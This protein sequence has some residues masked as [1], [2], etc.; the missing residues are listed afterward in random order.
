MVAVVVVGRPGYSLTVRSQ[1][2]PQIHGGVREIR[3]I[4]PLHPQTNL[5]LDGVWG[6]SIVRFLSDT[7]NL[8]LLAVWSGRV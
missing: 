1:P 6:R 5:V 3:I 7:N 2:Q 4:Q 8:W